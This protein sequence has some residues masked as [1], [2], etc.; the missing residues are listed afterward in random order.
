MPLERLHLVTTSSL[1]LLVAAGLCCLAAT[2]GGDD[3]RQFAYNGFA[4]AGL[5]LDGVATVTPNGLLMLTNG[6]IQ[7]KGHAFHP[8]P[9]P[10]RAAR[11]FST[12]FVFAIF[13]QYID[14]SSPGM[15]FF[16]TTSREVLSAALL[17]LP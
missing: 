15:A 6:T 17:E 12:T 11:S 14:L 1:L 9:V 13:G 2:A 16:V 7:K 4:G 5:T 3:G 10:L 8:S